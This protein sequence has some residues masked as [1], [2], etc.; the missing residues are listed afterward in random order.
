MI[1]S[2]NIATYSFLAILINTGKHSF[3]NMGQLIKKSGD[4]ISR[5]LRPGLESL[6]V[7][8]KIAQQIF[9]NKKELVVAIDE[10]TIKKIYSQMMEG[11]GWLF[12]TKISRCISAYKLIVAS[13]TDGKFT[14]PI[15][16]AFTF[17]KEFYVD[18]SMAQEVTVQF[19]IKTARSLF[20][21]ATIIAA[22]DGAFATVRY[23][24]WA[25]ENTIATEV[26][27]HANRVVEYKGK[28]K[29]LRDIKEIR[30]KGRQM[31]RTVKVIWQGLS[32]YITAVR[33]IDK[34]GDETIVFQAATYKATPSKHAKMYKRRWGIEKFFRTTK[35]SM[36]L[37]ECFSR[38]IGVQFN[39]IC[40]VL[41]AYSITQLEMKQRLYK[42]PEEAIRAFKKR[43][44][45][46][47]NHAMTVL[48]E[49]FGIARA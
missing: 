3:E 26:R 37:Q 31:A 25:T 13:I 38:K 16:A 10:T 4:T 8:K 1:I 33:R 7:S 42:N 46:D 49:N 9:A 24:K 41:L 44:H 29:K 17:G 36:G 47:L 23:L 40:A 11:T 39:H 43:K 2:N 14:V 6:D 22:L 35:Q 12:D 34:H 21:E 28:K 20:P 19:F 18:P 30:P 32:L 48:D 5:I 27:M 15:C 45:H